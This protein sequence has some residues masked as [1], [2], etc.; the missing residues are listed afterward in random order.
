M[1]YNFLGGVMKKIIILVIILLESMFLIVKAS[2]SHLEVKNELNRINLKNFN[3][4]MIVAHP[5]DEMLWGGSKLLS[6]NYLVVC[7][8]CSTNHKRELEFKK[9]MNE[10]KDKY[11]MLG[12][13][14]K[15]NGKVDDWK[16]YK[17]KIA[18]DLNEII[19]YKK[20]NLIVTHNPKGEYGHIHHKMTS[21]I[22]T[23][24][25]PIDNLYYFGRYYRPKQMTKERIKSLKK[26]DDD[27]LKQKREILKIYKTQK[28]IFKRFGHMFV[29]ENWVKGSE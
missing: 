15:I 14:D 11:I 13:P 21:K 12:Y 3:N 17:E 9:V 4:L 29:Y 27:I 8:T 2:P 1:W 18:N 25:A 20:W 10:T 5:D 7:I 22:T 24:L 19:N 16:N 28:F 26:I 23:S 6:D